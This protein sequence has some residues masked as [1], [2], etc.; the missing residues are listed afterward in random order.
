MAIK[1]TRTQISETPSESR[2]KNSL[3]EGYKR[4]LTEAGEGEDED[5]DLGGEDD[6]D[7]DL[8]NDL[9]LEGGEE[10][11]EDMGGEMG[12]DPNAIPTSPL[13]ALTDTESEQVNAWIDELLGD[14]INA[15][16]VD[17]AESLDTE[18]PSA[19]INPMGEQNFVHDDLP[20]TV[21]ELQNII[22][23]DDSLGALETGLADLAVA[24]EE[25]TETPAGLGEDPLGTDPLADDDNLNPITENEEPMNENAET[26]LVEAEDPMKGIDKYFDQGYQGEDVKDELTEDVDL[27]PNNKE[28]GMEEVPAGLNDKITS[29]VT[30]TP[31]SRTADSI[32]ADQ[33]GV[34]TE[35]KKLSEMLVK[36]ANVIDKQRADLAKSKKIVEGLKLENFRLIKANGLLSVAGDQLS[37]EA[38]TQ[39]SEGF[40]KC[41]TVDQINK[42]YTS[43]TEKIKNASRPSLNQVAG[44]KKTKINVIKESV[45]NAAKAE[46]ITHEQMRKN[47]LMGLDTK[48]DVYFQ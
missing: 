22:D 38:R 25:G 48:N 47:M 40:D 7:L 9:D 45:N 32:E 35:T 6:T 21:D 5:L 34:V 19:D 31:G 14:S 3:K 36:A 13:D 41:Q 12:E 29:T 23:S 42:F 4:F 43:L 26:E 30:A 15:V 1:N 27:A 44:S 20:M 18:I 46:Q 11:G 2:L 28:I 33:K 17:G 24:Q 37:K 16:E 10:G 39:I 8:D